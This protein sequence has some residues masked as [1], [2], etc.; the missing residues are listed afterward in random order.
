MN[1]FKNRLTSRKFLITL[2]GALVVLLS[3][4][5]VILLD[6]NNA[7]QLIAILLSYLGIEG[8]ADVASAWRRGQ[9]PQAEEATPSQ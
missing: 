1:S 6:D 4:S 8:A 7:W 2:M 5:G 3:N 9:L